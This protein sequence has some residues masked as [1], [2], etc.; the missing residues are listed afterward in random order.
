VADDVS[1]A[2]RTSRFKTVRAVPLPSRRI[3]V[4]KRI[5]QITMAISETTQRAAKPH[6]ERNATIARSSKGNSMELRIQ[7]KLLK[8]T[9]L[10]TSGQGCRALVALRRAAELRC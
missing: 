7:R 2:P 10:A 3:V 8:L 1:P 5:V 6:V 4:R 9:V